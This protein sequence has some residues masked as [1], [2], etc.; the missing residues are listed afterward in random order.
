MPT[1]NEINI[2]YAM[3]L[4]LNGLTAFALLAEFVTSRQLFIKYALIAQVLSLAWHTVNIFLT[5]HPTSESLL[6]V[7]TALLTLS[8][9]WFLAATADD[10]RL[11]NR[12]LAAIA[13]PY[14]VLLSVDYFFRLGLDVPLGYFTLLIFIATP[15]VALVLVRSGFRI[16]L[17]ILQFSA[18]TA[19][20]TGVA[21]LGGVNEAI[22]ALLYLLAALLF[23][24]VSICFVILSANYAR[25]RVA[26]SERT[27][28]VFFE[29]VD[30]VFFEVDEDLRIVN[31]SPSISQFGLSP[32]E[33]LNT[34][35]YEL[36]NEAEKFRRYAHAAKMNNEAFMLV[37]R[38]H[39]T[40]GLVDCE[41]TCTPMYDED[42]K[43]LRFAGTIRNVH[44]RNLLERQFINAQRHESLGKLAGGIAHDFNNILQGIMGHAELLKK[45]G[46][47]EK[48]Q[49]ASLGA[50][51]RATTTA[52][53]LC[54][55][56]LLY[57]GTGANVKEDLDLYELIKEV[58]EI[59]QPSLDDD[60]ELDISKVRQPICIRGD[61]AQIAQVV[62]NLIKNA[63]ESADSAVKVKVE[64][65]TE[66][67]TEPLSIDAQIAGKLSP[68]EYAKFTVEDNGKGIDPVIIGRIFDPFFTTK[69]K[70]HG[71]GLAAIV[72]ILAAH[73]GAVTV[74]S[75]KNKSTVFT[76]WLPVIAEP[77]IQQLMPVSEAA[78]SLRVLHV[79]D[80][81]DLVAV[82]KAMLEQMGHDVLVATSGLEALDI[83]S[84]SEIELDLII[85]DIKM[86]G[87][88]G[89]TLIRKLLTLYPRLS[90]VLASGYA[91][92]SS[93]LTV[94]ETSRI[95][96]L[97]KP[98]NY[99]ELLAA[100]EKSRAKAR[101][102][103]VTD[104]DPATA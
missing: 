50:I 33:V 87:M 48:K 1:V 93:S 18:A 104:K 80:E 47:T 8:G 91:D 14:L 85:S 78:E 95:E 41:V 43:S 84:D 37:G 26:A 61:K 88:D 56:L 40:Q 49:Q 12:S 52:G 36:L 103:T 39:S 70:G 7:S 76:V 86:P 45:S 73:E 66:L 60:S 90:V 94:S 17:A 19:L 54:R 81:E 23:P 16:P 101:F 25:R 65:T 22:G 28:R 5:I 3:I 64:L 53:G 83:M 74:Q 46:M 57:A 92:V 21:L 27:Y 24:I 72:G 38:L 96:I 59:M 77:D 30:D 79:D 99:N 6:Y 97:A 32:Q 42:K 55:Q 29:A 35:I 67:L 11:N 34:K 102:V 58:A 15:L 31:I 63:I 2:S 89:I 20:F 98:Y 69:L 100:V 44:E 68:G 71:L 82:G 75:E 62:M 13:V 9:L 51:T 10:V 4:G